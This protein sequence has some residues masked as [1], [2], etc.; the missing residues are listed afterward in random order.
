MVH[1]KWSLQWGRD[2]NSRSLGHESSPLT[3]RPRRLKKKKKKK[4]KF[5]ESSFD[6]LLVF[7][8]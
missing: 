8:L 1:D 5:L 3:T 7:K 2:S 4:K 6:N